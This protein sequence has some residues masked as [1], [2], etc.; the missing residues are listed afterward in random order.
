LR[1][2]MRKLLAETPASDAPVA[3]LARHDPVVAYADEPLRIV[4]YRMAETGFTRLPVIDPNGKRLVGIVSLED[5][6]RAR[7]RNLTEERQRERVL[8]VRLP[9]SA[10]AEAM[11]DTKGA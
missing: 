11:S 1:K 3:T 2:D 7:A 5:L 4:V 9:L 6:L 8:R 10:R